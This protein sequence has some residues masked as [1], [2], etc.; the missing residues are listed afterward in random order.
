MPHT[1]NDMT[2]EAA[3]AAVQW[4]AS[5]GADEGVGDVAINRFAAPATPEQAPT[6]KLVE[7]KAAPS[8]PVMA[9]RTA[10]AE[11]AIA[12]ARKVAAACNSL[13]DIEEA[14]SR[15]VACPLSRTATR[16]VFTDGLITAKLLIVGDYPG[17]EDDETGKPFAG[18]EGQLLDRMIAAIGQSR[19]TALITHLA[20]WRPPGGRAA[21]E[22]ETQ[23]CL[24]FLERL[25]QIVRPQV[26]LCLGEA[27]A[28]RLTGA[29]TGM[30]KLRGKWGNFNDVPV[31]ATWHPRNLIK[32]A[33][34]KADAWKDLLSLKD[35]LDAAAAS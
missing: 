3:L 24:P 23:M 25:I 28:Q 12:D 18:P 34:L 11:A 5:M 2:P 7:R 27:P 4:L 14:L 9:D 30:L 15:F 31:I 1:I 26:I 20:F 13:S 22:P 16:L 21:N 19:E 17:R 29:T 8:S 32:N 6:A 33:G 10:D 35:K